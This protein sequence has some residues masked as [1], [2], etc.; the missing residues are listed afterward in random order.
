[1][2]GD[3]HR[4]VLSTGSFLSN[5]GELRFGQNNT[6]YQIIKIVKFSLIPYS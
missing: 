2:K 4:Y 5:I 1:M 3:I 6:G